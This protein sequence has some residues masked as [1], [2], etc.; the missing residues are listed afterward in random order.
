MRYVDFAL[1]YAKRG[2]D[3]FPLK[4]NS[5]YPMKDFSWDKLATR[6]EEKILAFWKDN[7]DANIGI[8]TGARS[9]IIVV[10]VDVKNG[11]HGEDSFNALLISRGDFSDT[12]TSKTPSGGFHL[13]FKHPG[14]EIRNSASKLDDGIDIRCDGGYIVAPP[15][16]CD[17]KRYEWDKDHLLSKTE[18]LEMPQWMIDILL[19][20]EKKVETEQQEPSGKIPSGKRDTHLTSLAGT[21]H[22]R[23]MGYDAVLAALLEENKNKCVPPLKEAQVIKIAKSIG[24]YE[25]EQPSETEALKSRADELE[26]LFCAS[27]YSDP[28]YALINAGW[29]QQYYLMVPQLKR[30]WTKIKNGSDRVAAANECNILSELIELQAKVATNDVDKFAAQLSKN[31]YLETVSFRIGDI[32]KMIASGETD[33]IQ[34]II[35][36]ISGICPST[37]RKPKTAEQ[38]INDFLDVLHN[39]EGRS[40]K[41]YIPELDN[42]TG[43]LERQTLTILAARP[44]VGKSTLAWQIA[45][46]VANFQRK[47]LFVSLEMSA[48]Q[49]WAKAVCGALGI[50]WRDVRDGKV[51]LLTLQRIEDEAKRFSKL[52]EDR[53]LIDDAPNDTD[54]IYRNVSISRPDLLVIDHLRLLKDQSTNE[55]IRLGMITQKLKDIAKRFNCA[56]LLLA[57]LNRQT[58][59]RDEKRP[60]LADLRDS[61]QIE[62]NADNVI[63]LYRESYYDDDDSKNEKYSTTEALI[64]KFRDDILNQRAV[65]RFNTV[66]QW[67]E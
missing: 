18:I 57:Q 31:A 39:L 15:S 33:K 49:L 11:A 22:K 4:R 52:Y 30:F 40:I 51:D 41:S 66:T 32:Q 36:E 8:A 38:S 60:Q 10:D 2:F 46:S 44:S 21:M 55:V 61:G 62:E 37:D 14:I 16:I 19:A 58:E 29:V 53:L 1:E 35:N 3:V 67:F 17:G 47:S 9:G 7:P 24:K 26:W 54:M 48:A 27:V 12:P 65:L 13:L 59:A 28:E 23:G 45:R 42:K 43:G 63:M 5:K 64:R 6:E 56:V 50:R 25:R 20:D 34:T